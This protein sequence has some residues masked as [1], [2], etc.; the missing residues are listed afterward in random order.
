LNGASEKEKFFCKCSFTGIR[1]G[2]N[3]ESSPLFYFVFVFH[4]L[5]GVQR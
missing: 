4:V 2:D 5:I 1:V 3:G